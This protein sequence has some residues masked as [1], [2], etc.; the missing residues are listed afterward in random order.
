MLAPIALTM[1]EPAGIGGEVTLKAWLARRDANLPCFFAIDDPDRLERLSRRLNWPIKIKPIDDPGEAPAVFGHALPVLARP[2]PGDVTPGVVNA[3]NAPAVISAIDAAIDLTLSG[4]ACAMVT[5]PINKHA[6][7]TTGF[8]YAGHTDYLAERGGG[9]PVM[10]L[11]CP[12]LRVVP[13]TVHASLRDA[14]DSLNA[15]L[16]VEK[17]KIVSA[18]LSQDFGISTPRIVIAGL[19]PHAGERGLL[20]TEE[21]DFIEPAI[22]V[23]KRSGISVR[24]PVPSDTMFHD[25]AR[26]NYDAAIC[27]YHDQALI[28]IKTLDFFNG[29]NITLGLNFIRTSPDHGTAFEIA[30]TGVA[31]E[32]SLVAALKTAASMARQRQIE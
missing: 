3:Q 8:K 23:L 18:A 9:V 26:E 22:E 4:D 27:M 32:R 30:G 20:G 1:G 24:G 16:I 15:D 17:T 5:N 19:N 14:I 2:L 31:D 28:P 10:M 29:V 25:S 6:L 11:A 21:L 12:E 13:L 7:M